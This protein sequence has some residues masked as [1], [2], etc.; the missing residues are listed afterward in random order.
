MMSKSVVILTGERGVGKSTVC[1]KTVARSQSRGYTCGGLITLR[2]DTL[3]VRDV[4]SGDTRRLTLDSKVAPAVVQ[5]RF[6]FDPMTLA[7]G[8]DVL[9]QAVPCHLLVVDELGPLEFE[10]GLG[11]RRAFEVLHR[12]DFVLALTV[13]RPELVQEAQAR[14][15][16]DLITVLTVTLENRDDLPVKLVEMLEEE[17]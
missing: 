15:S 13:V 14:L 7:W 17:S 8:N 16:A 9:A 4:S 10:R 5:G 12:G 2:H 6:R 11:W 3:D 1:D